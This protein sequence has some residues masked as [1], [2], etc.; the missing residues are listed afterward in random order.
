M[1]ALKLGRGLLAS[2]F[3]SSCMNYDVWYR[4]FKFFTFEEI[5]QHILHC[6]IANAEIRKKIY[7]A[8][9]DSIDA[10][11]LLEEARAIQEDWS[12]EEDWKYNQWIEYQYGEDFAAEDSEEDTE[13][14]MDYYD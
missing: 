6:N 5:S 3:A 8:Y 1:S 2:E 14:D 11:D 13:E 4:I 10:N 12:Y 7:D 9:L